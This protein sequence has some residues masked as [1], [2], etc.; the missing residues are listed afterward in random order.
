MSHEYNLPFEQFEKY[1][2]ALCIIAKQR[3]LIESGP[4]KVKEKAIKLM[5]EKLLKNSD[6]IE[7]M[8]LN[9]SENQGGH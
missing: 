3:E 7:E 4:D 5:I 8:I 9:R 6:G 1:N 2:L